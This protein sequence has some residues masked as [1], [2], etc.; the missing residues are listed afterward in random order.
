MNL[1]FLRTVMAIAHSPSLSAAAHDLG[2]SHSAVSQ[3]IKALE[4][5]LRFQILDRSKRPP[6]LTGEGLALVEH[7]RRIEDIAGDIRSLADGSRLRGQVRIG[8][9]PSTVT[10]LA[11]PALATLCAAHPDLK[12]DLITAL[13]ERVLTQVVDGSLDL[14][15]VTDPGSEDHDLALTLICEEPVE[16]IFSAADAAGDPFT[17]LTERPFVWFDRRSRLSQQI[18]GVLTEKNIRV[19]SAMEVDSFEAVTALVEHGLGV[20]MLPHRIG[21]PDPP[22]VRRRRLPWGSPARRVVLASRW[23]SPRRLFAATLAEALRG[24]LATHQAA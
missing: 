15:L 8:V 5:E 19:R 9:V 18:Q 24:A 6:V 12:I 20:S 16:L 17:L 3:H 4:D 21:T 7:A 23:A 2:I 14:G 13:S 10:N 22:G 11:A 1:R